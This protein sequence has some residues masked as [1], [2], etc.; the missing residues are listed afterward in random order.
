MEFIIQLGEQLIKKKI[1]GIGE[2]FQS[3]RTVFNEEEG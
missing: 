1:F 2:E 3:N